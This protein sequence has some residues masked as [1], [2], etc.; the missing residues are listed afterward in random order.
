M[1]DSR[2]V[3]RALAWAALLGALSTSSI[4]AQSAP[5]A[6]RRPNILLIISDDV[7]IDMNTGMYPGLV[8]AAARQ[9]GPQGR[10]HP[11]YR[12]IE[13]H[14]A[15]TPNLDRLAR[16]G[17]AFSHAWAQPFCSPTRASILTG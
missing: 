3:R 2:H 16:Q 10:N 6:P 17:T 8:Q 14:T 7:G 12:A 5:D 15:S 13:G 1:S 9:Y 11:G 4:A